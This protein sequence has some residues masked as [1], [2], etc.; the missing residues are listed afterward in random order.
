MADVKVSALTAL[1]GADLANGDQFLVT[2]VGSPNVSKSIT[3]DQL[4]QG[5]QF[6]SRFVPKS[7][8][9]LWIPATAMGLQQGS[10]TLGSAALGAPSWLLD[11]SSQEGIAFTF[12]PPQWWS[13]F[14]LSLWWT[15]AGAGSGDVSWGFFTGTAGD[16]ESFSVQTTNQG[17]T[18]VAAPSQDVIKSTATLGSPFTVQSAELFGM[19]ILRRAAV[20]AD[21]LTNDVGVL[22]VVAT[23]AS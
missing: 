11:A 23:R 1:T 14:N 16:G 17:D 12:Y 2:D 13:T 4:A 5:S 8:N 19:I 3:A 21:T 7:G 20:A 18:T 10:P 9:T 22:G 15:N 6:S